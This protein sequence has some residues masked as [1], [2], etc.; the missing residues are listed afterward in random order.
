MSDQV[1]LNVAQALQNAQGSQVTLKVAKTIVI[2]LGACSLPSLDT[3]QMKHALLDCGDGTE[4]YCIGHFEFTSTNPNRCSMHCL[5]A[6]RPQRHT[7][8]CPAAVHKSYNTK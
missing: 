7:V 2:V 8:N 5:T 6:D 1:V 4:S 3:I